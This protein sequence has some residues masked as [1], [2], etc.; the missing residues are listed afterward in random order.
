MFRLLRYFLVTVLVAF[1]AATVLLAVLYRQS[2]INDLV[3]LEESSNVA[4][5]QAFANSLWDRFAPYVTSAAQLTGDELR[6]HPETAALRQAVLAQME[7]LPVLKVKIYDLTGLTVFSS[8]AAQIGEDKGTNAGFLS[9]RSGAVASELTHRDTFSA[10][11]GM[12]EDRDLVSSYIPVRRDGPAASIAG[13]LE[14][15][16]DVTPLLQRIERVQGNIAVAI[17]LTL[18]LLYA[19]LFFVL[20]RVSGQIRRQMAETQQAEDALRAA[21]AELEQR[22]EQRTEQLR[23]SAEVGRAAV[24]ILDPDQLLREVVN[25]IADRFQFY[26]AAMFTLD[27]SGKFAVLRAATGEAGRV[28]EERGHKL[29]VDD[30]SMVGAAIATRKTRIALDIGQEP[31]RFVNPLLPQTRSEIALPLVVGDHVFGVLDVQSTQEAAFDETSAAVLQAMADQIAIAL[32]NANSYAE[33]QT[34]VQ[35]SSALYKASQHVGRLESDLTTTVNAMLQTVSRPLGISQWWVVR[36][37]ENRERLVPLASS[38][39]T[40]K[41][42]TVRV[43]GQPDSPVVRSALHGETHLIN[44]PVNDPRMHAIPE[45]RRAGIGKHLSV[46]IF[47]RGTTIGAVSFGRALDEPDLTEHDLDV[48]RSL[49]GLTAIAIENRDLLAQTQRALDEVDAINRRLTGEAWTSFSRR[50]NRDGMM[51]VGSGSPEDRSQLPEII[52]ALSI[53][54]IAVRPTAEAGHLGVAVPILLRGAPIG[55]L[56]LSLPEY[57]WSSEMAATLESIAGHVAQAA[58]NARLVEMAEVRARRERAL[59][60]ATDKIR[61]KANVE[62]IL[63]TAAEEL[64]HHLKAA[65]VAVRLDVEDEPTNGSDGTGN[66]QV[67]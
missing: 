30:E 15:Y 22:I 46:P 8:E 19:S 53:G 25:L 29:K 27:E 58:E 28:L 9:A 55:A 2:A 6:S 34:A 35:R 3:E 33:A 21:Q 45:D 24:S 36:L 14:I 48:G 11:E 4:L 26:F 13:V 1:T 17:T 42:R 49:A 12:V 5:T 51:W 65:R 38:L 37:D 64:A 39:S 56:R 31:M 41:S 40:G 59:A 57:V 44:D 16:T 20:R 52:E 10:F 67:G 23:T 66:G 60:E 54:R 47:S 62:H 43:A 61:R 50:L 63:Q 32:N 7:G 18:A